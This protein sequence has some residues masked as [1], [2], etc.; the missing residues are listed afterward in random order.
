ME[1]KNRNLKI[2]SQLEPT[3]SIKRPIGV[4]MITLCVMVFGWMSYQGLPMNLMPEID[5]PTLT[6]RTEYPAATPMQVE[7]DVSKLIERQI[8]NLDNLQTSSSVSRA[9]M[10]DVV[11]EFKWDTDMDKVVQQV[12]ERVDTLRLPDGA[13]KP[14][15]LRY[16]PNL[17]PV[18]RLALTI[19]AD[20]GKNSLYRLREIAENV[21]ER[22]LEGV[23]GLAAIKIKGGLEEQI[24]IYL[25]EE[26]LKQHGLSAPQI[27]AQIA[28]WNRNSPVGTMT[29]GQR[30]FLVRLAG[31]FEN[32][33]EMLDLPL[34]RQQSSQGAAGATTPFDSSELTLR[35]IADIERTHKEESEMTR[36]DGKP[37][38]V[39]ELYRTA[40]A[41]IVA[42]SQRIRDKLFGTE[43]DRSLWLSQLISEARTAAKR[44]R[45]FDHARGILELADFRY[46]DEDSKKVIDVARREVDE[47]YQEWEKAKTDPELA[48]RLEEQRNQAQ[49]SQSSRG[50]SSQGPSRGGPRGGGMPSNE[51][52]VVRFIEKELPS[53]ASLTILSDQSEFI[54]GA[55]DEVTSAVL[56][57]ALL[58]I[59]VIYLFIR[60]FYDTFIISLSIPISVVVVFAPMKMFGVSLNIM[61]LGGLALGCGMLVDNSIVVL[62]SIFRCR[63]EGD[64]VIQSAVRGSKEVGGAVIASTLTTICVFLPLVFVEG[65][66]GQIFGDL[67]RTVVYS[68]VAS[69]VVAIFIIPMLASRS[70][71]ITKF[72]PTKSDFFR[73]KSVEF[74]K[75]QFRDFKIHHAILMPLYLVSFVIYVV[76]ELFY[77]FAVLP[78][79]ISGAAIAWFVFFIA[80]WT[81]FIVLFP[82]ALLFRI[83]YGFVEKTYAPL[84]K[85]ALTAKFAVLL[86]AGALLAFSATLIPL[87]GFQL[88]PDLQQGQF[89]MVVN[90]KPGSDIDDTDAVVK[91]LEEAMIPYIK[92]DRAEMD[93]VDAGEGGNVAGGDASGVK[94]KED[95][96]LIEAMFA[97]VGVEPTKDAK[98]GEGEHT[99]KITITMRP[100]M[101]TERNELLLRDILSE[102]SRQPE[103]H[104]APEF[105][106]PTL[107]SFSAPV[108]VHI[109]GHNLDEIRALGVRVRDELQTLDALTNTTCTVA[110][111]LP[112]VHIH[113]DRSKLSNYGIALSDVSERLNQMIEGVSSTSFKEKDERIDIFVSVQREFAGDDGSVRQAI[114]GIDHLRELYISPGQRLS[115]VLLSEIVP[116]VAD[117][118]QQLRLIDGLRFMEGPN[119]I[120]RIEGQRAVVVTSELSGF[121]LGAA[122]NQIRE[123]IGDMVAS[124]DWPAETRYQIAGQSLEMEESTNS[125]ILAL[126]LSAFL[127]Y[128]VMASQF[129]SFVQPFIIMFSL[130]LAFVGVVVTLFVWDIPVSVIVFIGAIML[131]GIVV[132][133]AIVMVSYINQLR[134]RGMEKYEAI[135]TGASVRLR[136][137][138]MTTFTTV[139]GLLPMTGLVN[140]GAMYAW[141]VKTVFGEG[142]DF[143]GN[144]AH[145]AVAAASQ[146]SEMRA[147]LAITV[148]AGLLSST[149]LTL[150][151]IPCVYSVID[152]SGLKKK[153]AED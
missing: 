78:L 12:R 56:V 132:N 39:I 43:D 89:Q 143:Y 115:D 130:P 86:L 35:E 131:A 60:R 152:F 58:A 7:E 91:K 22:E 68:L 21:L 34:T 9:E 83:C 146:G 142:S 36:V 74:L 42:L 45:L 136:P 80:R 100:E 128:V 149:I 122:T 117:G 27:S 52:V 104:G 139:L 110:P 62:E 54:Q 33:D 99:A 147:P 111:G 134:E 50:Q 66:A 17:E 26:A 19:P 30:D 6:I 18:M 76:L 10:S 46:R 84:L 8:S 92:K 49:Q 133:N 57:G 69:L 16:D 72:R 70:V 48:R 3:L 82:F 106:H 1:S 129:E 65:I 25:D 14:I 40:D 118:E 145:Y 125:L 108:E 11:L 28:S 44:D 138:F 31:E 114:E 109:I 119:E 116:V 38:V 61:S 127:V 107:F 73:L 93:K 96:S 95:E 77:K 112:E 123:R 29:E 137:I 135:I 63:S 51:D 87:L 47:I 53:D 120:R 105:I 15:L 88:L 94:K 24:R 151:V 23:D 144:V 2:E 150:F 71:D 4:V 20:E 85:S 13:A 121:D 153:L 102:V 41:N 141:I 140:F 98:T 124:P 32:I 67:S 64:S 113:L 5:Y 126:I 103:V 75:E 97:Q 90:L 81:A 55:I 101:A 79:L 37:A 148:I 59:L